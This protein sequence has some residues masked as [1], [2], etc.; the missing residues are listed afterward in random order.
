[1]NKG[2]LL[3]LF[4]LSFCISVSAEIITLQQGLDGYNG[5]TDSYIWHADGDGFKDQNWGD[6]DTIEID[7][8]HY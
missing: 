5:C 7:A 6:S 1:M 4:L 3:V 2:I 8:C